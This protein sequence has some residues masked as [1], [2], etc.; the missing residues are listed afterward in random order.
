MR[1][2]ANE[3]FPLRSAHILRAT[4]F[5]ISVVGVEHEG[6]TDH[7]VMQIAIAEARTIITFDRHYGELIFRHGYRPPAGV[8]YLRWR[9]FGPED[10]GRYLV[11]LLKSAEID[12][13]HA[14]TVIDEDTIRQRR[15]KPANST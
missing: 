6:I 1:L 11:E 14:L 13:S 8:V 2:L 5:D 12:F 10:P 9:R 15:Y 4:G 7:E 3:N